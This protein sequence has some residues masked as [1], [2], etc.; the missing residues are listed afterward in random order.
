[1]SHRALSRYLRHSMFE[2]LRRKGDNIK[3]YGYSAS[4][5]E[6][7][8]LVSLKVNIPPHM[9]SIISSSDIEEELLELIKTQET[10]RREI[11]NGKLTRK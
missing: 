9:Q 5:D 2:R 3:V 6:N 4:H 11:I 1:M 7:V 8:H 10:V